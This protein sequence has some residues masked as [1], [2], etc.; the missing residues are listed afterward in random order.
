MTVQ[1]PVDATELGFTLPHEHVFFDHTSLL[2]GKAGGDDSAR[3]TA[4]VRLEDLGKLTRDPFASRENLIFHEEDVATREVRRYLEAG[5]KTIVDLTVPNAGRNPEELRRLADTTGVNIVVGTGR[6]SHNG[7]A[8]SLDS[9]NPESLDSENPEVLARSMIEEIEN[10]I[11][12]T[13][14]RPGIIGEIGLQGR[15]GSPE[16]TILRAAALAQVET[17]LSISVQNPL[18]GENQSLEVIAVLTAAGARPERLIIG[19]VGEEIRDLD[20]QK[21][22]ADTGVMLEYGRFGAEFYYES[23]GHHR[24]PRDIEMVDAVTRLIE[25]G[26]SRQ[27]LLS[28]GLRFRIEFAAFGGWGFS[29]ITDHIV[30]YLRDRG[31]S[32]VEIENVTARNPAR[33]LELAT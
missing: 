7:H 32:D 30:L 9:E 29:H 17:G 10:G 6:W 31:V 1:G 16:E 15:I 4:P 18:P 5:G 21:A 13:G 11:G 12:E 2:L 19:Q 22:V 28:H 27:V 20:F 24:H 14:I 33:L 23:S 26:Y 25:E 3:A 8:G